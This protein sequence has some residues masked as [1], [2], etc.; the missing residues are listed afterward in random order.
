[1][2]IV[3]KPWVGDEAEW[4]SP[5]E[6]GG[7]LK[8]R[9]LLLGNP[10]VPVG[11]RW[12]PQRMY[13]VTQD[14]RGRPRRI[15]DMPN[16]SSDGIMATSR[17]REVLEPIVGNDAEFL[18]V[19]GGREMMWL[20]NPW[21][22]VDALDEEKSD[23]KRFNNSERIM[24]VTKYVFRPEALAGVTYFRVPQLGARMFVTAPVVEAVH[25]AG[26]T[27]IDFRRLWSDAA[28]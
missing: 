7:H 6:P 3:Y 9:D 26:L 21:R 19:T 28:G 14:D 10:G 16:Y 5:V 11:D 15:V 4:A 24:K 18:E 23:L 2:M 25:A 22:V 12:V 17:A 13:M 20:V 27:G 8:I 1:M